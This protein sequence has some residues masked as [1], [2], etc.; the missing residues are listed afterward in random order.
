[1]ASEKALSPRQTKIYS[2]RMHAMVKGATTPGASPI[3]S[4]VVETMQAAARKHALAQTALRLGK[5]KLRPV[6]AKASAQAA[7]TKAAVAVKQVAALKAQPAGRSR[8]GGPALYFKEGYGTKYPTGP[9]Q[10]GKKGG[11]FLLINGNKY[12]VGKK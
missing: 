4:Q 3:T 6:S 12:Y 11:T 1:M 2:E 7:K 10:K 8:A 5:D 9:L